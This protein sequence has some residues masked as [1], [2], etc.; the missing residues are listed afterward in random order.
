MACHATPP[1]R[2][3]EAACQAT[4]GN[5]G[6][7]VC[8]KP[9]AITMMV[10]AALVNW[11]LFTASSYLLLWSPMLAALDLNLAQQLLFGSDTLLM[12]GGFQRYNCDTA[13]LEHGTPVSNLWTYPLI[14]QW[15]DRTNNGQVESLQAR[16]QAT[17]Q[18][19]M[20]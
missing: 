5:S 17:P 10:I 6:L 3:K 14:Q 20:Q 9:C 19:Q 7:A 1:G 12:G 13:H 2:E 16:A 18:H 4:E 8:P 15:E 11:H